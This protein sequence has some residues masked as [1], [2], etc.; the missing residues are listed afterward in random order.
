MSE[1]EKKIRDDLA[2]ILAQTIEAQI[3]FPNRAKTW[4]FVRTKIEHALNKL[5]VFDFGDKTI[6]PE[7]L[8]I[9]SH[10]LKDASERIYEQEAQGD[11]I[12]TSSKRGRK[13]K[14]V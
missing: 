10:V 5:G 1:Q 9:V 13:P 6:I 2:K 11:V 4:L 7:S 14:E 3:D 8:P 12:A